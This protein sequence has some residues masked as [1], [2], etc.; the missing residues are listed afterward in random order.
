M[1][2]L[3]LIGAIAAALGW[4]TARAVVR[5][6]RIEGSTAPRRVAELAFFAAALV[7]Q[8]L[9]L[10]LIRSR[11][12]RLTDE[13]FDA[14][15]RLR[16]WVEVQDSLGKSRAEVSALAAQMA[17]RGMLRLD[18]DQLAEHA[19]LTRAMLDEAQD[20]GECAAVVRG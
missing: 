1:A 6:R 15:P 19:S 5:A 14:S 9:D 16:H 17:H 10:R 7:A 12:A 2:N 11:G 20:A 18:R 4:L 13:L 3:A 8:V